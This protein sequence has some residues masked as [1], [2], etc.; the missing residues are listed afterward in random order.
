MAYKVLYRKYRPN[1]FEKI[2]GQK[3][4]VENL[5][6]SV[7]EG[8][9]SHA[10]IFTGPRGTGKTT[11]AKVLA[12]SL[13]CIDPHGGESCDK[14]ENCTNFTTIPDIIEIDAA[15]NNGI[16]EIRELRNNITLAPS[17]AKYKI[18]IIDEVHM[19]SDGA[20]NALL[21][22]LEEPPAHAIFILATT[23]I[24]KVPITILSRCQRYD[25]K[26][27]DQNDMIAH[28]K[29]I[30]NEENISYED[31]VLEEIFE[32]SEGCLRDALS[33]L[34]QSSKSESKITLEG[35][36]KNYNMIS[37][38]AVK[39]LLTLVKGGQID[40]LIKKI[41]SYEAT[42]INAQKML[43]RMI[44]YLE[45]IAIEIKIGKTKEFPYSTIS[46][47][48][49]DLNKCY[50][51]A[52]IN[53]NVF[54]MIK[55]CFLEAVESPLKRKNE[56]KE[57]KM[58]KDVKKEGAEKPLEEQVNIKEKEQ[59]VEQQTLNPIEIRIN[60]CFV[61]ASKDH[62]SEITNKWNIL[63]SKTMPGLEPKEYKPV[64]ASST[65]AIFTSEENSLANLFNIKQEE[66]EKL[67]KKEQIDIKVVAITNDEWQKEKERY[68]NNLIQ[69]KKYEYIE[70]PFPK[71]ESSKIKK[72]AEDLFNEKLVEVS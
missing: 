57:E 16:N 71:E 1:T 66:I 17:Q 42:G 14:C 22:T 23:E 60:N 20:F 53:E 5:K 15:S 55:L 59:N 12:K 41:E 56:P 50:I 63:T 58:N 47:L 2:V 9:F 37:N 40:D 43:K 7:D 6:K 28:L 32:L 54:T 36:L 68:K 64:A 13:I 11:T 25:F 18:Y 48:I 39:E 30:C 33:I 4:I 29:D 31:G 8:S 3:T 70:E 62:L 24:Y 26:K 69:K 46:L 65:Y 27:I 10:Y 49:K 52:R 34:D 72:E 35:L 45:K 21:K 67:L 44:S 51:D 38:N 19:L 61:E